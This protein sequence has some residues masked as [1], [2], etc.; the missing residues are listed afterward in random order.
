MEPGLDLGLLIRCARKADQDT[1]G[2]HQNFMVL[3]SAEVP[4]NGAL[5]LQRRGAENFPAPLVA[6]PKRTGVPANVRFTPESG[7]WN[8]VSKCPLCA[9]SGSSMFNRLPCPRSL[10]WKVGA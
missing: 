2:G 3:E 10:R 9:K 7:H 1:E 4:L 6:T 8:S 5:H